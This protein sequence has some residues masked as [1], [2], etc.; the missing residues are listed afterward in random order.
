MIQK[1]LYLVA[2]E[3]NI[4]SGI[5]KWANVGMTERTAEARLKDQDYARKS[6]G[7]NWRVLDKWDIPGYTDHDVHKLMQAAG[8]QL[9]PNKTGNSEEFA[10]KL[11]IDDTIALISGFVNQLLTGVKRKDNFAPRSEQNVCV[12]KAY[13]YLTTNAGSPFLFDAKMRFGKTFVT[14]LLGARLNAKNILIITWKPSVS[15]SWLSDLK[16][17]VKFDGWGWKHIG[18]DVEN[19]IAAA[20]KPTVTFVSMQMLLANKETNENELYE[21]EHGDIIESQMLNKTSEVFDTAW[22]LVAFDEVH[23]GERTINAQ[24]IFRNLTRSHTVYLS[25][26]PYKLVANYQFDDASTFTWSYSDEQ[27]AKRAD[28]ALGANKTGAYDMLPAMTRVLI[29]LSGV[30]AL[31]DLVKQYSEDE[32]FRIEKMLGVNKETGEFEDIPTVRR[33]I[34]CL[35]KNGVARGYSPWAMKNI[36]IRMFDTTLWFLPSVASI[37]ALA[38]MLKVNTFFK[39]FDIIQTSGKNRN[40]KSIT[41]LQARIKA[42]NKD[43]R[44]SIILACERFKEGVTLPEL[45][46]VFMMNGWSSPE[47]YYQASFRCQSPWAMA[48]DPITEQV[49]EWKQNCY[50]FDFNPSRALRLSYE[51]AYTESM[52][53]DKTVEECLQRFHD[54]CPVIDNAGVIWKN[55]IT[56][57][58]RLGLHSKSPAERIASG[59]YIGKSNLMELIEDFKGIERSGAIVHQQIIN[60]EVEKGKLYKPSANSNN[61]PKTQMEKVDWTEMIEKVQTVLKHLPTIVFCHPEL[62]L[63]SCNSI[64]KSVDGKTFKDITDV[65]LKVFK[66]MIARQVVGT[67]HDKCLLDYSVRLRKLN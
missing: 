37:S 19:I 42:K 66:R 57:A 1:S 22:D 24:E 62:T 6:A 32:G 54:N 38:A 18:H 58:F 2:A 36:D 43:G 29:D 41:D 56:E 33:F 65:D 14:Y 55:D 13:K 30:K 64:V 35:E 45:G 49:T 23:Y 9:D 59:F 53:S 51:Y 34:E 28:Q 50:V 67:F 48:T 10:P 7:G 11:P 4:E 21:D 52:K 8:Y 3:R 39:E 46:A 5:V 25:G 12:N 15:D 31:S 63:D 60:D 20:N 47:S 17:H 27:E 61:R 16:N 40:V 44:K 26:T